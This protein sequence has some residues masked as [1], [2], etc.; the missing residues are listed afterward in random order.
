[1]V[2]ELLDGKV[3]LG[4][5]LPLVVEL[6]LQMDFF[7]FLFTGYFLELYDFIFVYQIISFMTFLYVLYHPEEFFFFFYEIF[8]LNLTDIYL[9]YQLL[10]KFGVVFD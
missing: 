1:M 10:S 4:C 7:I 9:V 2:I 6:H 8:A 5:Q 3:I